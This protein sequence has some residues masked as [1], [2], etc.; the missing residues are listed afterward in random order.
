MVERKAGVL[1]P[2]GLWDP[3]EPAPSIRWEPD[4]QAVEAARQLLAPL[5]RPRI[6]LQAGSHAGRALLAPRRRRD[7]SPDW[8][9]STGT[10]LAQG[11]G[12]SLAVHAS[13]ME[14][15]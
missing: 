4:P 10:A 9:V 11:L 5:P 8:L 3:A 14:R 7:P 13:G 6:G 12:A 1:V 2:L 15:T